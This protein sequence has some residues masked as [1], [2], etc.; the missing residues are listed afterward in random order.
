MVSKLAAIAL[1]VLLAAGCTASPRSGKSRS[2]PAPTA[3]ASS[4]PSSRLASS[5]SLCLP[6]TVASKARLVEILDRVDE[7]TLTVRLGDRITAHAYG[8]CQPV[9]DGSAKGK[10]DQLTLTGRNQWTVRHAGT[11]TLTFAGGV[12]ALLPKSDPPCAGPLAFFGRVIVKVP[13][14]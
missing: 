10:T 5:L 14:S 7:P 9:V 6:I 8:S 12:C 1:V 3:P 4:P 11:T 13:S 2:T